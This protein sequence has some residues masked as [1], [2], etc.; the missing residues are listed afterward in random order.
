MNIPTLDQLA[1]LPEEEAVQRYFD[2]I[3]YRVLRWILAGAFI[4]AFIM[5]ISFSNAR[6]PAHVFPQQVPLA[7]VHVGVLSAMIF[8]RKHPFFARHFRTILLSYVAVEYL[9]GISIFFSVEPIAAASLGIFP[10]M[11][12][13][14]RLRTREYL[15]LASLFV[16]GNS[17]TALVLQGSIG[18]AITS[19]FIPAVLVSAGFFG[20]SF[21]AMRTERRRFVGEWRAI[22]SREHDRMRMLE[23]LEVARQIQIS[24]LPEEAPQLDW[25]EL[26]GVSRPATEVG[27]DF[28]DFFVLDE[29]RVAI[30]V[31]DVAGH[32][33]PSGIVLTAVKSGLYLLRK[34]LDD[35]AGAMAALNDMVRDAIRWRMLVSMIV[36]IVDR[37]QGTIRIVCAGHP[38]MLHLSRATGELHE[39]GLG[40]L[41]IGSKLP[42][43]YSITEQRF[44]EG[45]ML[46]FVTDG[47]TELA[48]GSEVFGDER[49]TALMREHTGGA[50]QL[51]DALIVALD[52]FRA[53]VPADD[54]ITIVTARLR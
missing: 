24:M 18:K 44:G 35:L 39:I 37:R 2:G 31:G 29:E 25:I 49:L 11:V 41:P 10:A 1:L 32:G 45:D 27:G 38:P 3:N 40:S 16:L 47:V 42:V 12:F 54:D 28:F 5:A 17:V 9:L 22:S 36:A 51:R 4:V 33:L 34:Q 48:K 53:G 14:L 13:L 21:A 46:L 15:M 30:V 26:A 52:T 6:Y 43:T 50:V 23:E 8:S 20:L 7:I 19:H